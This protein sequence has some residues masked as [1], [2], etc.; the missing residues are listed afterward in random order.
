[1]EQEDVYDNE[2]KLK[3]FK[4]RVLRSSVEFRKVQQE[5]CKNNYLKFKLEIIKSFEIFDELMNMKRIQDTG[6]TH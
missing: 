4:K 1:M 6:R 2:K 3:I 5:L